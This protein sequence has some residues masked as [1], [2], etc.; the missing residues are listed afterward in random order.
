MLVTEMTNLHVAFLRKV[1]GPVQPSFP[2]F[3]VVRFGSLDLALEIAHTC[4][5]K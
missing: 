5:R 4:Y 1:Q 3:A 2:H